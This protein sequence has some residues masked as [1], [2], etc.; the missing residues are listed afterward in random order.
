MMENPFD[1]IRKKREQAALLKKQQ[2]EA[3]QKTEEN[4][5]NESQRLFLQYSERYSPMVE[6][7]LKQ[8]REALYP[9]DV[10]LNG[11]HP[12]KTYQNSW[13][14]PDPD[15]WRPTWELRHSAEEQLSD[16]SGPS[17]VTYTDVQ[18]ILD[19]DKKRNPI[20][21]CQR[22]Q[23]PKV[24]CPATDTDLARTLYKLHE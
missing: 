18:I 5:K 10:E 19:F 15:I 20:F 16:T 6:R 4:K 8:L 11:P 9:A 3:K 7:I 24:S 14:K 1:E 2:E 23:S 13:E 22:A 12:F 21:V 17:N